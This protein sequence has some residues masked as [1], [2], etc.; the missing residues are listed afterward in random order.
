MNT[1]H[2]HASLPSP[3]QRPT[4]AKSLP[5]LLLLPEDPIP[6]P[7]P[8]SPR[9]KPAKAT[10]T[11][12]DDDGAVHS[13]DDAVV[14]VFVLVVVVTA[15]SWKVSSSAVPACIIINKNQTNHQPAVHHFVVSIHTIHTYM[16]ILFVIFRTRSLTAHSSPV[17]AIE[18]VFLFVGKYEI[19]N[20]RL[21]RACLHETN[22]VS[23]VVMVVVVVTAAAPW[24]APSSSAVPACAQPTTQQPITACGRQ[25][26]V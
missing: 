7:P 16:G 26:A 15:A 4:A 11:P 24:T 2:R 10:T 18:F 6:L 19:S 25:P 20:T 13:E 8:Q 5:L 1:C 21:G 14:L 12:D 17:D 9:V 22:L 3:E 23:H